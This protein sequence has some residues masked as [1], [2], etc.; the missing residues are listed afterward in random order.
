[1]SKIDKLHA[2]LIERG[3]TVAVAESCTG[4]L[5]GAALTSRSGSSAYFQGGILSYSNEVKHRGLGVSQ[6]TL[7][8]FGAVSEQVAKEMA[9]GAFKRFGVDVAVSVTGIAGPTGG[10]ADKPVGL[11]YIGLCDANGPRAER[12]IWQ[13]DREENRRSSVE[14]ALQMLIDWVG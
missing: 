7:D 5:V 8:Q 12:F 11:T 10:T 9:E 6:I 4:G 14:A 3:K 13:G 1:M 2:K